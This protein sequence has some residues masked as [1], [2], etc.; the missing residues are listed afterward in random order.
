[1]KH[2]FIDINQKRLKYATSKSKLTKKYK[3]IEKS[4]SVKQLMTTNSNRLP[5]TITMIASILCAT[6]AVALGEQ[7]EKVESSTTFEHEAETESEDKDL[8]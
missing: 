5:K 4:L 3:T 8:W 2:V 7:S 1:M 6:I